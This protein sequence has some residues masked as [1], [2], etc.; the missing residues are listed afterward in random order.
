MSRNDDATR[1]RVLAAIGAGA[2]AGLAGCAGGDEPTDEPTDTPTDEPAMESTDTPTD[3]TDGDTANVRVVHASPDAP[4]VDVAVDGDTVLEDVAFGTVSDY[5]AVPGGDRT[6]SITPTGGME[7]VFDGT[8]SVTAEEDYTVVAA[9]EVGDMADTSFDPLVLADDNS[10]PM[11]GDARV[12]VVHV[13]PD[14]PAVD[15]TTGTEPTVLVDGAAYRD[16]ASVSVAAGDYTLD[17]RGDTESNDGDVVGSFDVSLEGGQVYTAFAVGYLTADDE[18]AD[19][20]FD[21]VVA[22]DTGGM[23]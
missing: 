23:M 20:A 22:Q 14:A 2:A 13:S 12:R 1:R 15:V 17:V 10:E 9:G 5:L 4:N 18:S 7:A 21:L 16:A 8:V 11:D 6:V 19:T 3:G